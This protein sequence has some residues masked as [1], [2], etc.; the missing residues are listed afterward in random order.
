[1]LTEQAV[2]LAGPGGRHAAG[3][4][5][6]GAMLSLLVFLGVLVLFGWF[7]AL[8]TEP[9]LDAKLDIVIGGALVGIALILRRRRPRESKPRAARRAMVC[10]RRWASASCR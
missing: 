10:V 1:M 6:A 8:P 7:I 3:R 9:H 2:I 4:Y 5:A